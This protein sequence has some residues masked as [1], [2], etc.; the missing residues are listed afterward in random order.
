VYQPK[1]LEVDIPAGVHD[2]SIIRLAGQGE[3]GKGGASAGNL[4]LHVRLEPHSL[5]KVVDD[6]DVQ[7]DLP[8]VPWEAAMGA[9][10][11]VPTIESP[12]EM[13]IPAGVE[14]GQRLRLRGQGLRKREGGRGDQF[15][16]IKMVNP[17]NL[18]DKERELYRELAKV[19]KF[20]ARDLIGG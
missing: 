2:G 10:V 4:F 14:T 20:N 18:T 19:S 13:T 6:H 16:K 5:F 1:T 17:P 15:V 9:K 3:P 11:S 12:V 7:I 8:L